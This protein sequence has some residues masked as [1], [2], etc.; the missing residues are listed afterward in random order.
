VRRQLFLVA[1][2]A[3]ILSTFFPASSYGPWVVAADNVS[4]PGNPSVQAVDQ[5][6][7]ILL[8]RH[9]EKV[10]PGDNVPLTLAGELRA[11]Q[12]AHVAGDAGIKAIY[13]TDWKRTKAT[14]APL[15]TCL[16]LKPIDYSEA[17]Q[18]VDKLNAEHAGQTVL[19]V[20]HHQTIQEIIDALAGPGS[21]RDR[22]SAYDSL[23][24]L[25]HYAPGKVSILR[26]KYGQIVTNPVCAPQ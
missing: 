11:K 18:L 19:V 17:K 23:T 15:A 4:L 24:V 14:V 26:L 8:V 25:C 9:A 7:T 3:G 5:P 1:L 16:A 21:S 10:E 13:T 22:D 12:L 6:T 20:S 2:A